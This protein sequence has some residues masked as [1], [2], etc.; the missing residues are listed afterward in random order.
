MTF[1]GEDTPVLD[2]GTSLVPT[3][4]VGAGSKTKRC[5]PTA[6]RESEAIRHG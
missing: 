3:Q 2:H 5:V 4:S 1:A 6:R